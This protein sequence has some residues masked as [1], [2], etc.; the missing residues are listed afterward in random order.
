MTNVLPL[1]GVVVSVT[2]ATLLTIPVTLVCLMQVG[3]FSR[4]MVAR[5]EAKHREQGTRMESLGRLARGIAHDMNN[6]M[7]TITGHA[8]LA[9]IQSGGNNKHLARVISGCKKASLLLERMLTYSGGSK[10]ATVA[11]DIKAPIEASAESMIS[12]LGKH[13]KLNIQIQDYLPDVRIDGTDLENCILN[14]LINSSQAIGDRKGVITLR[15]LY[16]LEARLPEGTVGSSVTGPAV[17][18]EVE[19]TGIGIPVSARPHV[20]E[21]FYSTKQG[22]KGLGLVNVLST[23]NSAGGAIWYSSEEGVGTRFVLW[24]PGWGKNA[25]SGGGMEEICSLEALIVEDDPDV[26]EVLELM[27]ESFGVKCTVVNSATKAIRKIEEFPEVKYSVAIVDINLGEGDIDG[28]RVSR[29][30]LDGGHAHGILI[31]SGD[32]PGI[33]LAQFE[34]EPVLFKRKPVSMKDL[35]SACM[36][37]RDVSERA[38]G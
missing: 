9:R 25:C 22:G 1:F 6:V 38:T 13:Q 36:E 18:I 34:G 31:I 35:E 14:L 20:L 23:V 19:D 21:P 29:L 5:N 33:R 4:D 16:E 37:L 27:V 17:R 7:Y 26:A 15:V 30:L 24:L 32:E 8:E 28:I 2:E 12:V 3:A 10:P 11:I